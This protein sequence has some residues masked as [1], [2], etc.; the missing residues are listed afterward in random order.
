MFAI[1]ISPEDTGG[2]LPLPIQGTIA[3]ASSGLFLVI[4]LILIAYKFFTLK[5]IGAGK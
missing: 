1:L 5:K 2:F 4:S 3:V